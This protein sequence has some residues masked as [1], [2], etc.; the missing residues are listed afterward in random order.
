ML[1]MGEFGPE[2]YEGRDDIDKV[3]FAGDALPAHLTYEF[4]TDTEILTF[5]D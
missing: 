2:K 1:R 3:T 4:D 5:S